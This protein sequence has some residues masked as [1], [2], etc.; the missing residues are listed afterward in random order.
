MVGSG[1]EE[2]LR[3]RNPN[4]TE[5]NAHR[6]PIVWVKRRPYADMMYRAFRRDYRVDEPG[7]GESQ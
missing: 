4:Y 3:C 2:L 5:S 7:V 1:W 6:D